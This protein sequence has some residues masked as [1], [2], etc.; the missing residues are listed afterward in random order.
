MLLGSWKN[1]FY[2]AES[3]INYYEWS[4]GSESGYDDIKNFTR[5]EAECGENN[6]LERLYFKEGHAY[7]IS[8]KVNSFSCVRFECI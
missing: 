1:V 6:E 4:I 3:E 2:D 7:Y 8:V 5:V